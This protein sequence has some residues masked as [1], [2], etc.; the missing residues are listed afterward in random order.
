MKSNSRLQPLIVSA[1][2]CGLFAPAFAPLPVFA[3]NARLLNKQTGQEFQ[4]G[5]ARVGIFRQNIGSNSAALFASGGYV[6]ADLVAEFTFSE[7]YTR[8][9]FM[10][11]RNDHDDRVFSVSQSSSQTLAQ[12]GRLEGEKFKIAS[13]QELVAACAAGHGPSG[14]TYTIVYGAKV[15]ISAKGMDDDDPGIDYDGQFVTKIREIPIQVECREVLPP[16]ETYAKV[17]PLEWSFECPEGFTIQGR[18]VRTVTSNSSKIQLCAAPG[19]ILP[20]LPITG[21]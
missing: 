21:P 20:A 14:E 15:Q 8:I 12:T 6:K 17:V 1:L 10:N 9:D 3:D 13:I 7:D 2:L 16:A 11:M 19:D 5:E 4:P 18:N